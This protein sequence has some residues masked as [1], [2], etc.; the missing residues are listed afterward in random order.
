MQRI[1][2]GD[3]VEVIAGKDKG[4]RGRVVRINNKNGRVVVERVNIIKKHQRAMQAGRRQVNPGIIEYEGE[5][6][7]S[8]V[9][10]ICPETGKKTRIGF[11][12][13]EDG[14]K[15]R[16]AKVSGAELD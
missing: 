13:R 9:M 7:L 1:K 11:R 2:V 14:R 8:N 3:E 15:V 12:V 5:I 10:P 6:D 16:Y 4:A